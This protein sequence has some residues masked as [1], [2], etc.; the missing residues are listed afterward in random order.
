MGLTTFDI[1]SLRDIWGRLSPHET[2]HKRDCIPSLRDIW[3]RFS[4]HEKGVIT[5]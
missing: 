5:E 3:G 4:P 2:E 1:P